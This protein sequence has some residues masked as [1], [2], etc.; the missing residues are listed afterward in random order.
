MCNF[1][2]FHFSVFNGSYMSIL[3][4]DGRQWC[5]IRFLDPNHARIVV[6]KMDGFIWR[7]H[8]LVVKQVSILISLSTFFKLP[9]FFWLGFGRDTWVGRKG[10]PASRCAW[11]GDTHGQYPQVLEF[12]EVLGHQ[13]GCY[14]KQRWWKPISLCM[15][16]F[17]KLTPENASLG[18]IV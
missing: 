11:W 15:A 5:T 4:V 16:Y 10:G 7:G 13:R 3:D 14:E 17:C 18:N 2:Q 12:S 9:Q 8:K 1:S 6:E